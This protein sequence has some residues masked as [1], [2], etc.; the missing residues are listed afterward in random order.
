MRCPR[1]VSEATG[2]RTERGIASPDRAAR[3]GPHASPRCGKSRR[4]WRIMGA[5]GGMAVGRGPS[6]R[7]QASPYAFHRG[8][9]PRIKAMG[10]TCAE[11]F[12]TTGA[13]PPC[14]ARWHTLQGAIA[15]GLKS[16]STLMRRIRSRCPWPASAT[17]AMGSN[18]RSARWPRDQ[19]M[20]PC[21]RGLNSWWDSAGCNAPPPARDR[22]LVVR[23]M[24]LGRAGAYG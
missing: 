16:L 17:R 13:C 3:S 12:C 20:W 23:L 21:S 10:R 8:L 7:P 9:A 22:P 15:P 6:N 11:P 1:Q 19:G 24:R 14:R 5:A 18:A 4:S 2:L